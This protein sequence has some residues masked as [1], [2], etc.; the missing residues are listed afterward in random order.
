MS[1]V[2]AVSRCLGMNGI[3]EVLCNRD[4]VKRHGKF[5]VSVYCTEQGC[6]RLK[7]YLPRSLSLMVARA[8]DQAPACL[9]P[10]SFLK[11]VCCTC[12]RALPSQRDKSHEI[13]RVTVWKFQ[14]CEEIPKHQ[15]L[16]EGYNT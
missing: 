13:A 3:A 12:P 4:T 5:A 11:H 7:K 14:A 10:R 2:L 15:K 9:S 8:R 6:M 16:I 1:C